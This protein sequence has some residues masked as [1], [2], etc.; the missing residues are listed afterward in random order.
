MTAP[1]SDAEPTNETNVTGN[2]STVSHVIIPAENPP[3][4]SPLSGVKRVAPGFNPSTS[5]QDNICSEMAQPHVVAATNSETNVPPVAKRSRPN[6][7]G[8]R[9]GKWTTEEQAYADRLIRDF[10]EGILP[11]E[12]GA[13]LRA[14]LSKK[15]N[16]D[17]MRISKKFAGAKCLGKQIFLKRTSESDD[18]KYDVDVLKKLEADF[19]RSISTAATGSNARRRN[20]SGSSANTNISSSKMETSTMLPSETL[21]CS[22]PAS[23]VT[24]SDEGE[25]DED[26][27]SDMSTT[28]PALLKLDMSS[29]SSDEDV[30]SSSDESSLDIPSVSSLL[31]ID[32]I[33]EAMNAL[34]AE[35]IVF[36]TSSPANFGTSQSTHESAGNSNASA[37][38]SNALCDED[39]NLLAG[40]LIE[41][42]ADFLPD[43]CFGIEAY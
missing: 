24:F 10:E 15:L 19:I 12:N 35:L 20:R 8:V 27:D 42:L 11:L 37:G 31:V 2:R 6:R 23:K 41:P 32:D 5:T 38:N 14:F 28:R 26:T 18:C 1:T 33:R 7:E 22:N 29:G 40:E 21:D 13:T 17:P 25:T 9:R 34:S 39:L 4:S 16:C 30:C 36:P 3:A 43:E